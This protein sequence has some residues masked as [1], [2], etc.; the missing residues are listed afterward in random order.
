M[1]E[2]EAHAMRLPASGTIFLVYEYS[3]SLY[4]SSSLSLSSLTSMFCYV[5]VQGEDGL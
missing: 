4:S 1:A 3:S 2:T 5:V